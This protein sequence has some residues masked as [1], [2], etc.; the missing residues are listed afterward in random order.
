MHHFSLAFINFLAL[1]TVHLA[2]SAAIFDSLWRLKPMILG[3]I[4]VPSQMIYILTIF[5]PELILMRLLQCLEHQLS[6]ALQNFDDLA[7]DQTKFLR[8]IQR[9]YMIFKKIGEVFGANVVMLFITYLVQLI[10]SVYFT[11]AFFVED[12]DMYDAHTKY[13]F[14]INWAM[15]S[16]ICIKRTFHVT[17]YTQRFLDS[18][19]KTLE[20]LIIMEAKTESGLERQEITMAKNLLLRIDGLPAHGFFKVDRSIL[21]TLLGHFLTYGIILLEFKLNALSRH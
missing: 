14:S 7:I 3:S 4:F 9:I 17:C 12:F 6:N 13:L 20:R 21:P 1:A 10:I 11:I 18:A 8:E 15:Y 19:Y 2:H 16:F 5:V